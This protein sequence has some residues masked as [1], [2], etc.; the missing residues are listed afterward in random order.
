MGGAGSEPTG[1]VPLGELSGRRDHF[2]D[3]ILFLK[4]Y[5]FS[6]NIYVLRGEH[7]ALVDA[8]NDYTAF[9][10]LFRLGFKPADIRQV[11]LT[12]THN[13]HVMGVVEL[14]RAYPSFGQTGF[15]LIFHEA[16]PPNLKAFADTFGARAVEVR[17]GEV[18]QLAGMPWEVIHTP[19]HTADGIC[20]YHAASRT[21]LTG[22]LVLPD[23]IAAPDD[24]AGGRLDQYL[25]SLRA[26]L[27]REVDNVLPGHGRPVIGSGRRAIE[28]TYEGVILRFTGEDA[29]PGWLDRAAELV[30]RGFLDEALFCCRRELEAWPGS[31][32]A[33]E[34]QGLCLNDLG[35]F[36]E[37]ILA[38]DRALALDHRRALALAGKG[39]ALMGL[40]RYTESVACFD[41]ALAQDPGLKE[42]L[43]YKGLALYLAGRYDEALDIEA[44]RTEF[45][46][47]LKQELQKVKRGGESGDKP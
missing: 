34:L 35:R 9:L 22:D 44:F 15:E 21:L 7:L 33:L 2:F 17:G 14:V 30:A 23:A 18:L 6:S 1:W 13:D 3:R 20:L 36:D 25:L 19:G 5:D 29:L 42:A 8:G 41:A 27:R 4:G 39:Y 32:R 31:I 40:G 46:G 24:F 28:E 47:R 12:H 38:F 11:L 10:E 43:V 37:A 16:A 26:L 45:T